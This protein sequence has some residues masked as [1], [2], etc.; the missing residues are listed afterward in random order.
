MIV[1]N[2]FITLVSSPD[3]IPKRRKGSGTYRILFL[4]TQDAAHHVTVMTTHRFGI[5]T[6]QP[7]SQAAIA[8]Y[9]AVSHDIT[10]KPYG[11]TPISATEF[12]NATPA[13]P[14]NR[15]MYTRPFPPFGDGVLGRD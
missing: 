6:H 7:L 5:A 13:S 3:P 1:P 15:L 4:G 10:C 8:G 12:R 2:V 9:S 11:A 14:R